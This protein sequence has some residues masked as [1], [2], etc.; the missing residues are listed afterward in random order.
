M[1]ADVAE[2]FKTKK[3]VTE[4]TADA[5]SCRSVADQPCHSRKVDGNENISVTTIT[6]KPETAQAVREKA[7]VIKATEQKTV[8]SVVETVWKQE[9]VH[10]VAD[11]RT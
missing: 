6:V 1:K 4:R 8:S 2:Q 9:T 7:T 11:D 5:R 10:Q 3:T